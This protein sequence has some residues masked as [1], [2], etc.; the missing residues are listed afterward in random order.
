MDEKKLFGLFLSKQISVAQFIETYFTG[1][2]SSYEYI[3]SIPAI[4]R[5]F[6]SVGL[7]SAKSNSRSEV[8]K[9]LKKQKGEG[10]QCA[11]STEILEESADYMVA[12]VT[13]KFESFTKK[14]T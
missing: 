4:H 14:L 5:V 8:V 3:L 10:L 6:L 9:Y 12:K 2:S 7:N 13:L 1:I 11:V